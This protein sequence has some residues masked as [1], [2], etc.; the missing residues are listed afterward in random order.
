MPPDNPADIPPGGDVAFPNTKETVGGVARFNHTQYVLFAPG[1]YK[2]EFAV[3]VVER[4]QLVVAL[5]G[6]EDSTTVFGTDSAGILIGVCTVR[7][8]GAN[9]L[10]TIRNP[11]ASAGAVSIPQ[12]SGGA[13]PASAALFISRLS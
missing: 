4:S 11:S 6:V 9:T 8:R 5:N 13:L 12:H 10:L 3:P 7:T 1:L 2:I